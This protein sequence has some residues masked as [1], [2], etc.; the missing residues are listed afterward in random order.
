MPMW[1][2][3]DGNREH[4]SSVVSCLEKCIQRLRRGYPVDIQSW[5]TIDFNSNE[6]TIDLQNTPIP[7]IS[8]VPKRGRA[9]GR[10]IYLQEKRDSKNERRQPTTMELLSVIF[11]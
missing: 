11:Q 5:L 10:Y 8:S 1:R 7:G 4:Q 3:T 9:Q 6:R 2:L